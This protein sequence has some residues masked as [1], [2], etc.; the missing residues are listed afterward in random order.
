MLDMLQKLGIPTDMFGDIVP[1]GTVLG[2]LL[3]LVAEETGAGMQDG[4]Q[5]V[6]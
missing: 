6:V 1:P 4:G 2:N 5:P 3:S